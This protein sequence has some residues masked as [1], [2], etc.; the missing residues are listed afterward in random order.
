MK[1]IIKQTILA[2]CLLL[3]AVNS[4]LANDPTSVPW[5]VGS[6]EAAMNSTKTLMN[7]YGDPQNDWSLG[8]FHCGL[9]FDSMTEPP[10]GTTQVRCVHGDQEPS[11]SSVV[12]S[13]IY[14][15]WEGII[16]N[17]LL[18]LPR[19]QENP[20]MMIMAGVTSI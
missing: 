10:L 13:D 16:L 2:I 11:P 5:P 12:I 19:V 15:V 8:R 7:S 9:D 17:G 20:I 6:T 14:D 1:I 3:S 18:L 4:S